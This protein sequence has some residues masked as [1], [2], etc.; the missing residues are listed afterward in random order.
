MKTSFSFTGKTILVVDDDSDYLFQSKTRLE[1]LGFHVI[2]AGSV[3]D[4]Q[5]LIESTNFD[6]AI[7]DLMMETRDAGIVLAHTIKKK[8]PQVPVLLVTGMTRETGITLGDT[9]DVMQWVKA[10]RIMPK[11]IRFEN[12]AWELQILMTA[13]T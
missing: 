8:V 11:P 6:A 9:Q 10:D 3:K 7:L 2:T 5:L 12:L 13:R 4:A 1:A